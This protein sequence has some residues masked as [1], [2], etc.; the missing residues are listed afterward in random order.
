MSFL[1]LP[2]PLHNPVILMPNCP[3]NILVTYACYARSA[4]TVPLYPTL[5]S[6]AISF[7]LDQVRPS[8]CFVDADYLEAILAALGAAGGEHKGGALVVCNRALGD[9]DPALLAQLQASF[10]SVLAFG[11]LVS[12]G[13]EKRERLYSEGDT[14]CS[15]TERPHHPLDHTYIN[16]PSAHTCATISYTSGTTSLPKGVVLSHGNIQ[17]I[18]NSVFQ[19]AFIHVDSATR[20]FSY[21]PLPHIFERAVSSGI[22]GHGGSLSFMRSHPDPKVQASY[23]VPD[24]TAVK[25]TIFCCAPRVVNKLKGNVEMAVADDAAASRLIRHALA[26]KLASFRND[27]RVTHVAYDVL[28]NKV[29]AKIGL[30]SVQT[31]VC[32]SAPVD[33]A[34]LAFFSV[35]LPNAKVLEGYGLTE[36]SG[37][38][39]LNNADLYPDF[40]QFGTVG[41][42]VGGMEVKLVADAAGHD[43]RDVERGEIW[44]RGENVSDGYYAGENEDGT[45]KIANIKDKDGWFQTGDVGV[46]DATTGGL[47][48]VDRIKNIFKLQQGEF[49][50]VERIEGVVNSNVT[51]IEQCWAYGDPMRRFIVGVVT[52]DENWKSEAE[53]KLKEGETLEDVVL[54]DVYETCKASGLQGYECIRAIRIHSEPFSAANGFATPTFKLVRNKLKEEYMERIEEMYAELDRVQK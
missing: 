31:V 47:K 13:N 14:A 52:L 22:A 38:V 41:E 12:A 19:R 44:V 10:S 9:L 18:C 35:L 24:M 34:A 51:Y 42:P 4:H 6:G 5:G 23:L 39:S 8:V 37:G 46:W 50:S 16:P 1:D 45:M 36:T 20:H 29:S 15:D 49:V 2:L 27:N 32:G 21:L 11:D 54:K 26:S 48:I 25:P 7:I 3:Q 43:G 53:G 30:D 28:M 17:T 33:A 40:K